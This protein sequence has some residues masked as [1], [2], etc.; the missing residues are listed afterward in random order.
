[1]CVFFFVQ[2]TFGTILWGG[3][4]FFV[5]INQGKL[6]QFDYINF[7]K[8]LRTNKDIESLLE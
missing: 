3:Y 6:F 7:G 2:A 4:S 1:M 8:D 5:R